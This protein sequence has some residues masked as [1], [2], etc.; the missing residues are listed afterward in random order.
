MEGVGENAFEV[1]TSPV[2]IVT[3]DEATRAK[4]VNL[5]KP[6]VSHERTCIMSS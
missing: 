1:E 3:L 5:P 2:P 6:K 4:L